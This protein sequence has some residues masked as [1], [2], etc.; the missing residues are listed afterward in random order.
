M[1]SPRGEEYAFDMPPSF[2]SLAPHTP[3]AGHSLSPFRLGITLTILVASGLATA[4]GAVRRPAAP[5]APNILLI[6]VDD[7]G[8]ADLGCQG[9]PDIQSPHIDRLAASGL[10][11]TQGY[12]SAP[13]CGPSRAGVLTGINQE[14]FGYRNIDV[15]TGLP[16][17]EVVKTLPELLKERGYATGMIG[18]WHVGVNQH[19]K[20]TLIEPKDEAAVAARALRTLNEPWNRGF[21]W[22]VEMDGGMSH[23]YPYSESGKKWMT[24]RHREHRLREVQPATGTDTFLDLPEDTYLSD[25]FSQR[26]AEFIEGR[27]G[28][29]WFLY[30]SYNAPHTPLVAREDDLAKVTANPK[31]S[32]E[33]R[34]H[35]AVMAGLDRG[36]GV[37][38]D[39][40]DR[41]GQRDRTL[42]FFI[43][44]NGSPVWNTHGSN[45]PFAGEKGDV[46]EGGIRVPFIAAWPN[47][48]P[49]GKTYDE[50]A[51]AL[52]V[53]P[54]SLAAA[55][56]PLKTDDPGARFVEGV[57]LLPWLTG[58]RPGMPHERWFVLWSGKS[59]ARLGP[60]KEVRNPGATHSK[61]LPPHA[62]F[63]LSVNPGENPTRQLAEPG[64]RERLGR[65]LD[66]WLAGVETDAAT[67]TPPADPRMAGRSK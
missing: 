21:D 47:V 8:Y 23:Y 44:D 42:V 45:A 27:N 39:A 43:S 26:A 54:T 2:L 62:F 22:A 32:A 65:A 58:Q 34:Q 6:L 4:H 33:R 12:V 10:R 17:K 14:R 40:L 29:P 53:L 59:M 36:V 15:N 48:I 24:I 18:K 19:D 20:Q 13:Q 37:V 46:Y 25:Y 28:H 16:P 52:D 1:E 64:A 9:S 66:T 51:S 49:A 56:T 61:G 41:S 57:N 67:L 7:L 50:I 60:L 38:L 55:G 5:P 31:V 11:F 63:D 30:L 3:L 35:V